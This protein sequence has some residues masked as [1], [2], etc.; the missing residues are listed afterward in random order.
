MKISSHGGSTAGRGKLRGS[1]IN[2]GLVQAQLRD[3]RWVGL[4]LAAFDALDNLGQHGIG[5]LGRPSRRLHVVSH[6]DL[7]AGERKSGMGEET[8]QL[9]LEDLSLSRGQTFPGPSRNIGKADILSFAELTGD[10]HPIHYDDEYAKTTR[11]GRP[12]VHGLHLMALTALGASRLS[13]QLTAS[14]IALLEQQASFH[15]AVF[16]D[17]TVQSQ[18]EIEGIDHRPGREWGK[19]RIKVRL[20]NQ[21]DET[22]L[23]GRHVYAI[24]YRSGA[25]PQ[26]AA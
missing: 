1:F 17:D 9:F 16:E 10:K 14:M 5:T 4:E 26:G 8:K 18:F 3:V 11:F 25:G 2:A 13:Q 20:I 21:R 15:R 23:A 22:V 6:L 24:R 12:I 19:L 7:D